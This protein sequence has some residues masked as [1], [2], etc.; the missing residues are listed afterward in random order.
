MSESAFEYRPVVG[1]ETYM[2]PRTEPMLMIVPLL[3]AAMC[4]MAALQVRTIPNTFV[5]NVR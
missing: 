4:G 2:S 3:R 5:S 1:E